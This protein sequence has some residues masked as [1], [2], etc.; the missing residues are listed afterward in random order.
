MFTCG[1]RYRLTR[2][3]FS[4]TFNAH[5][6]KTVIK[7]LA[8][9]L[10]SLMLIACEEETDPPVP[11]GQQV[12]QTRNLTAASLSLQEATDI[13]FMREEEK[14]ARDVYISMYNRWNARVFQNISQSEA[15]HM[16]RML[17]LIETYGLTDPAAGQAVGA[18]TNPDLQAL[19]HTL[20]QTGNQSLVNA[21]KVGAEIEEIDILDLEDALQV[22]DPSHADIIQVYTQLKSASG[23]HLRAFVRN[24][25]AEGV[26]YVPQHMTPA[27]YQAIVP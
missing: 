5:M 22:V 2:G 24:L 16:S 11:Y 15:T 13:R 6:M 14:L 1:S 7:L 27:Q 25:D 10:L 26:T 9:P 19:Y 21:L 20:V 12:L 17:T 23:N 8:L 18:F 3:D 4:V